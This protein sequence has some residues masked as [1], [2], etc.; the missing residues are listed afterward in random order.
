MSEM[1]FEEMYKRQVEI[2][3]LNKVWELLSML[4]EQMYE[5]GK[6]YDKIRQFM[7]ENYDKKYA[8]LKKIGCGYHF[9]SKEECKRLCDAEN[10]QNI[11]KMMEYIKEYFDKVLIEGDNK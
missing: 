9:Y 7:H 1:T 4:S 2:K 5:A 8:A 3:E 11:D 10:S 6:K